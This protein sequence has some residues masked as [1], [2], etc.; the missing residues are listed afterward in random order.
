MVYIN[1]E[2]HKQK[3]ITEYL[4]RKSISR[5]YFAMSND[6]PWKCYSQHK[7]RV[8]TGSNR[9]NGGYVFLHEV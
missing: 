8:D 5:L 3:N 2:N 1:K 7:D 9:F 4:R 6:K